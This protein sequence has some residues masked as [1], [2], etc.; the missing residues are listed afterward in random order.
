MEFLRAV[1]TSLNQLLRS[2]REEEIDLNS[3]VFAF[4]DDVAFGTV[5]VVSKSYSPR[6]IQE[7]LEE[8]LRNGPSWVHANLVRGKT[9]TKVVVLEFGASVGNPRPTINV[10]YENSE[11][12]LT[13]P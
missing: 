3:L 10:S 4:A 12:T 1:V 8:K 7:I 11:I 6:N 2:G 5:C 13:V 9:G